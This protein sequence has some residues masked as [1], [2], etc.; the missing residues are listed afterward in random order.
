MNTATKFDEYYNGSGLYTS[1]GFVRT[2]H[3]SRPTSRPTD[4]VVIVGVIVTFA[5][6]IAAVVVLL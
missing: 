3:T 4:W 2:H 5:F 1:N 6:V